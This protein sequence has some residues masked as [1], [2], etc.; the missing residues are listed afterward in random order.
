MTVAQDAVEL[1]HVV[2]VNPGAVVATEFA[3]IEQGAIADACRA[4]AEVALVAKAAQRDLSYILFEL[5][6][7]IDVHRTDREEMALAAACR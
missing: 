1:A 2:G 6:E 7:E 5:V 3:G 4:H